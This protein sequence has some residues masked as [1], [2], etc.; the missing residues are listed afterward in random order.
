MY[1]PYD[2]EIRKK[3]NVNMK[4]SVFPSKMNKE[5]ILDTLTK[6]GVERDMVNLEVTNVLKEIKELKQNIEAKE[7]LLEAKLIELHNIDEDIIEISQLLPV[8]EK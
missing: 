4:M 2:W 8:F 3:D 1:N 6:K 5:C 7:V